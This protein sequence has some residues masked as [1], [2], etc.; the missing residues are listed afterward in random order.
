MNVNKD[1][2]KN[3]SLLF[4]R[5][6]RKS[7]IDEFNGNIITDNVRLLDFT[8]QERS[9]YDAHIHNNTKA[10]RDFLIKLC[11]DTSIDVETRN[12]VKNCKTFDEIQNVILANTKKKLSLS[13][14]KMDK[15]NNDIINLSKI[16]DRGF[17][18][19]ERDDYNDIF[20][21]IDQVKS[22][23]SILRRKLTNEKK[24]YDSMSRT[25]MYLKNAVDNIK[26]VDICPICLD[27]I[28]NDEI[29]ITKCGHKFCKTCIYE[30][31][32]QLV[33]RHYVT[34]CPKCNIEISVSDIYLLKDTPPD[35]NNIDSN[36]ELNE[37]I[38][39]VKSTKIG[40]IIH[41]IKA[42]MKETDK[43][44]IFSQWDTMLTKVGKLLKK[45]NINVLYCSGTVYKRKNA[46]KNF[47]ENMNSNIICLSSQHCAS[48]INLTAANKIILI[49]PIYGDKEYRKSI[50]NQAI[51]RVDRLGQQRPIE[52]IRFIIKDSIEEE[53]LN[54]NNENIRK[55]VDENEMEDNDILV[56]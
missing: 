39:R 55:N 11:C 43:C 32:D 10:N 35:I 16:I 34:K 26:T 30:Y 6:T 9:I 56:I 54:S 52:I 49:E 53:I 12:L 19:D 18:I 40:N 14:E 31:I 3:S 41:Y 27:D 20:E 7:I 47:Q 50:E 51:G 29:A 13:V 4:R 2:I 48:G 36:N 23:I 8:E 44:I 45:E 46:I 21:S 22:E 28:Q 5:N 38:Q 25:Y 17:I 33:N 42:E 15:F 24:E 37:L 1:M